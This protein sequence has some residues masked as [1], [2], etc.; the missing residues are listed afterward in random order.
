[1]IRSIFG[2]VLALLASGATAEE[3]AETMTFRLFRP[4]TGSASFC[5]SMVLAQG[6][7]DAGAPERLR[8]L[9]QNIDGYPMIVFDSP[10]GSL[11]AGLQ[12]GELI[13]KWGLS[14]GMGLSYSQETADGVTF[15]A[16]DVVCYSA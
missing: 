11:I 4:C 15:V 3:Y 16:T 14:T 12:M 10:G 6:E 9:L 13:R 2:V 8:T 5:G 1:M 7:L